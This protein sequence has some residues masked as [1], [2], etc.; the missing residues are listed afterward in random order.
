VTAERFAGRIAD[1]NDARGY[2][3][4]LPLDGGDRAFVHVKAFQGA[5]R[6]PVDGD[7][8]SYRPTRDAR[9]RLNAVDVRFAGQRIE[10]AGTGRKRPGNEGRPL[11]RA[12]I[13][14]AFLVAV[15]VAAVA[16]K[17]PLLVPVIHAVASLASALLYAV[18]KSAAGAGRQ[19][20]PEARL[21]LFDAAGGWP[22]A[23]VAQQRWRHKTV[24]ASFQA[25]FW[26]TVVVNLVAMAWLVKSGH[27][28]AISIEWFGH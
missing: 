13:G 28:A 12:A 14:I 15:C 17:L 11:P 1:W 23:L 25:T 5:T 8:I 16:G 10:T 24:K 4:V 2:G 27:A 3:F 26:G 6:R 22:G 19:R 20:I 9:G 18:D 21:H 7:L